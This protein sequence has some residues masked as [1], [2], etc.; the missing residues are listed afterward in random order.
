VPLPDA[1]NAMLTISNALPAAQGTYQVVATN[2]AGSVTSRVVRLTFNAQAL[3]IV[4]PPQSLTVA[5]GASARFDV[6]VSGVPPFSY[7]WLFAG[8]PILNAVNQDLTLLSASL[9]NAGSYRVV[10]TNAYLSVTSVSAVLTVIT[11]PVLS[12]AATSTN[13]LITC[14]GDPARTH[15]LDCTTNL[16]PGA[17]WTPVVTNPL[18][19]LGSITWPRPFPTNTPA[20]YRAVSP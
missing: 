19:A 3:S 17:I 13:L 18:S 14:R 16:G 12:I 7:Q 10:V 20:Y 5:A 4:S 1:T 8:N 11:P 15:R 6:L 9:T 2:F